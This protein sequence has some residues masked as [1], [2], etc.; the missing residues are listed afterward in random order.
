[1]NDDINNSEITLKEFMN[2]V[3]FPLDVDN[4]ES[5]KTTISFNVS[6]YKYIEGYFKDEKL[7]NVSSNDIELCL[8]YYRSKYRQRTGKIGM[9]PKSV[10]HIYST[11][12]RIFK[13]AKRKHYISENPMD[14]VKPPRVPRKEVNA[15]SE[16]ELKIFMEALSN[17]SEENGCML[18]LL[19]STGIRRGEC[20]GLQWQ[21]IDFEN[22][23]LHI[24]RNVT[25]VT[26]R[27]V[28]VGTPKT[29]ESSRDIPLSSNTSKVLLEHRQKQQLKFPN[30]DLQ[31]A[32]VFPSKEDPYLPCDPTSITRNVKSFLTDNGLPPHSPHDL[33]HTFGSLTYKQSK[34]SKTLQNLLG[35]SDIST[36]LNF[37]VR[38]ADMQEKRSVSE[39]YTS[40]YGL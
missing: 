36:T 21:D 1:M 14:D 6:M 40:A 35:H 23:R 3:W 19:V 25:R 37:Y 16:S 34:D 33:R 22:N 4:G 7:K 9:E 11:L 18:R 32:Y 39:K 30:I 38:R 29:S 8:N 13:C 10:K 31:C 26:G 15:L 28:I 24:R 17:T 20:A 5:K 27:G 2:D 12:V